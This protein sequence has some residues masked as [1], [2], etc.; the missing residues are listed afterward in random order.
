M[1]TL[2]RNLKRTENTD[3][4]EICRYLSTCVCGAHVRCS[5]HA[6]PMRT[7]VAYAHVCIAHAQVRVVYAHVRVSVCKH[8]G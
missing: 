8:L 1:K 7:C 2:Y 3:T 4:D 6:L 5:A